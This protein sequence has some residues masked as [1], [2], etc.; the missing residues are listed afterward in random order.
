[1]DYGNHVWSDTLYYAIDQVHAQRGAVSLNHLFGPQYYYEND[2]NETPAHRDARRTY[3]KRVYIGNRALGVDVLEVGYRQRGGCDLMHHLD[4]WD[5][6]NANM[7]FLTGNGVTDSHG[8]GPYQL[9]GWGPTE[10][11]LAWTNNFVTWMYTEELSEAGFV[12]AMKA[13]RAYFGDPYRWQGTLD[14]RTK[15][16]FRMGQVLLTDAPAHDVY[17]EVTGVPTDVEVRLLQVDMRDNV[18]PTYL[19]PLRLRDEAL[20]GSVVGNVFRDTVSVATT[21]P[22]FVRVEVYDGAGREMVFSNPLYF[23][24]TLPTRGVAAERVAARLGPIRVFRAEDFRLTAA[25]WDAGNLLL[26]LEGDEGTPGGGSISLD[27]GMLG[28]PHA[29][30]GAAAWSWLGG[31][32]EVQGF[33]GNGSAIDLSWGATDAAALPSTPAELR[34]APVRRIPRAGPRRSSSPC[35]GRAGRAW[36]SW[37]SPGAASGISWRTSGRPGARG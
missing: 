36:M 29:V 8:R 6:L 16:G 35:P 27:P 31:V 11:G 19:D 3:T 5:A 25:T 37:T 9:D 4:L 10:M 34:L 15:D 14:L 33:A 13:G 24:T 32:L 28:A 23:V 21:S 18:W 12:H 20:A 1:M 30:G 22:S 7:V 26:H 17:V 2:P